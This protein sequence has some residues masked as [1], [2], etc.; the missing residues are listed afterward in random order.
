[1]YMM[2]VVPY[3][4]AVF[5]IVILPKPIVSFGPFIVKDNVVVVVDWFEVIVALDTCEL[6]MFPVIAISI[7]APLSV[8]AGT[9]VG[10]GV[11]VGVGV[12]DG[13]DDG[14]GVRVAVGSSVGVGIGVS[15]AVGEGT[16]VG[17]G[18]N[19]ADSIYEA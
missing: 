2:G 13:V 11:S 16:I 18:A 14:V 10:N 12:G 7:I 15:V 8:L 1:M 3:C 9:V 4:M 5:G 19:V 6:V 17:V